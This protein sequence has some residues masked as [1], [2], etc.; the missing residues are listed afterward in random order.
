MPPSIVAFVGENEN[1]ILAAASR[2]L[3]AAATPP[4]FGWEVLNIF[5]AEWTKRL[6]TRVRDGGI[7]FGFGCAGV[8]WDVSV[9][10]PQSGGKKNFWD[11]LKIP[12]ISLLADQPAHLPRN[13][14]VAARYVANGYLIRDFFDLQRRV[15]R[16]PQISTVLPTAVTANPHR[17]RTP[18]SRRR[19]RMVFVKSGGD[20][21]AFRQSW[22]SFPARLRAV[23]EDASA[24]VLR[25]GTGDISDTL[26]SAFTAQQV[27]IGERHEL[28]LCALHKVDL[29]TRMVRGTRMAQALT[30]VPADIFGRG[31][32]H[33]D[34]TASKARFHPALDASGLAALYAETQYLVN[35]TP[36]FSMGVHERVPNGF[37][38]KACV[39]SDDNAFSR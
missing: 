10:D 6:N 24:E 33:I 26:S 39:I 28:F 20:P 9:A 4:G 21:E 32:E 2:D 13:H 8:G 15:I 27:E 25:G 23:I 18:W 34:T 19:H 11:A 16:S 3:L 7:V 5:D 35:T 31:W 29:Y 12:F 30:R 17:D 22:A 38:A 37:A 1:G 14:R 36:N